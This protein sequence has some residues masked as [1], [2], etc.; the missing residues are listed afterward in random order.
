VAQQAGILKE[1]RQLTRRPDFKGYL[2]D[3]GGPS[4]NM[5]GFECA[6]KQSTASVNTNVASTGSRARSCPLTTNIKW[7]YCKSSANSKASRKVFV[8]SGIRY[9]MVLA[10]KAHGRATCARSSPDTRPGR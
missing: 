4:A 2:Q 1:A 9:D 3:V 10:D 5:Y 7:H 8:A 6:K